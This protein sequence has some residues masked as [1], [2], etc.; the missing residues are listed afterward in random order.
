MV[1]EPLLDVAPDSAKPFRR[2]GMGYLYEPVNG[3]GRAL[4]IR[5]KADYLMR[6]AG[7]V[8]AELVVEATLPGVMPHLHQGRLNL[9]GTNSKRD[10]A[11]VLGEQTD[12]VNWRLVLEEFCVGILRA[13]RQG[14][15]GHRAVRRDAQGG[16]QPDERLAPAREILRHGVLRS[17]PRIPNSRCACTAMPRRS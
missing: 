17:H 2:D 10:L 12:I 4:G 3:D 11:K 16:L 8:T 1:V 15:P 7:D 5:L 6:R 9:D 14:D 13:E